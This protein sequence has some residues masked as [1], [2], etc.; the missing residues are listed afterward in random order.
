MLPFSN[1]PG[2][3]LKD[4][5]FFFF[6]F[7]FYYHFIIY[8]SIYFIFFWGGE[9]STHFN[10][11]ALDF[12]LTLGAHQLK[13]SNASKAIQFDIAVGESIIG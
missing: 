2:L 3:C 4:I 7:H 10:V 5:I 8:L 9:G 12:N 6:I 13:S 1:W 11:L